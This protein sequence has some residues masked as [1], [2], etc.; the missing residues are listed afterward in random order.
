VVWIL[1][2]DF[3]P[4]GDKLTSTGNGQT[5]TGETGDGQTVNGQSR[6]V[7]RPT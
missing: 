1:G 4:L 3:E 5:G 6:K 7:W 2:L